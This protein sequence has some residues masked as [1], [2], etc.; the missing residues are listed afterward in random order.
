MTVRFSNST[1]LPAIPD[2]D[3]NA[4]PHGMGLQFHLEGGGEVDV[5]LNSLGFFPV[6]TGEEF[7]QL[8]Q[9]AGES[10]KDA[11]KP[12]TLEQ[13][14]ASHPAVPKAF[15]TARTPTSFA[16][17]TYNGV[18]AFIFVAPDG[19]KSPFRFRIVPDAGAEYMTAEQAA[20]APRPTSW[21]MSWRSGWPPG[22]SSSACSRSSRTRA[23]PSTM[24]PGPGRTTASSPRWARSP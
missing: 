3:P 13:F 24:R 23:I 12:T 5:V 7:L 1:G 14:V 22:R 16:R 18:D 17:E 10:P 6:R 9:A 20:K 19:T 8:L 4:D 2:A 15:A 21:K 11:P